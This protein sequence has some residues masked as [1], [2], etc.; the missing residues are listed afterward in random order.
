M[1]TSH[2]ITG[3]AGGTDR[4]PG[5]SG[6]AQGTATCSG[7]TRGPSSS[8]ADPGLLRQSRGRLP[9]AG[10]PPSAWGRQVRA[11]T[12]R[13]SCPR[14]P[15]P[16][17][18]TTASGCRQPGSRRL[19]LPRKRRARE[20][21]SPPAPLRRSRPR[22]AGPSPVTAAA[23]PQPKHLSPAASAG[24]L[25]LSKMAL[26]AMTS[27]SPPPQARAGAGP[28][29]GSPE[30]RTRG[31]RGRWSWRAALGLEAWRCPEGPPRGCCWPSAPL[32][33]FAGRETAPG[34]PGPP[35]ASLA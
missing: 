9:A 12:F 23:S 28:P 24:F 25:S 8:E 19:R 11:L 15:G 4:K 32:G 13:P 26:R 14:P 18:S 30:G 3:G 2:R 21:R 5:A 33:S 10:R 22:A 35:G 20:P 6:P 27:L 7:V 34:P 29:G 17:R 16:A 31:R 1:G